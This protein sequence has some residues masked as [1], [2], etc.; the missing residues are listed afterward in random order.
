MKYRSA[1]SLTLLL[2][3]LSPAHGQ[4]SN[5]LVLSRTIS[6]PKVQGGFNH[7]SVDAE[8]LRLFAAAP[9][10]ATLESVDLSAGKPWRSLEG[11]KPAAARYAPEFNQLMSRAGKVCTSTT[12]LHLR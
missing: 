2:C 9:T 10:N 12:E 1:F 3:C 4:E 8:H 7:M 5:S 6:L 11:E